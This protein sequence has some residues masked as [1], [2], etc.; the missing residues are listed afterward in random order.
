M[1][2][3]I[4]EIKKTH[5]CNQLVSDNAGEEVVL[6]GWVHTRRDL[7]KLIFID[8]RDREGITQVVFNPEI[9]KT[10]HEVAKT[11]R[12]EDVI[13]IKGKVMKR[14]DPNKDMVTGEIEILVDY[15][16]IL[17][18]AK[19]TP[20]VIEDDVDASEELRLKYRYLDLRRP[21]LQKILKTRHHAA[22]I[23]RSYLSENGFIEVE[24]PVLTK[25]TPEGARDY[26]LPSRVSKG[27]FYAL[28]QS[29]QLFKQLLMISGLERYFQ[30]AKCYRDEDLRA[31]RQPEFTQIDCEM[32]F[33]NEEDIY[34][35]MEG[36]ITKIWKD[37]KGV[38]LKRPFDR[39]THA[40]AM[41]DYGTDRPDR[42]IPWK[43]KDLTILFKESDFKVFKS[44]EESG[45]KIKGMNVQ[46]RADLSR[47]VL[48]GL[49]EFVK[50]YG[51]KGLAWLKF[52]DNEWQGSV[53][54]FLSDKEKDGLKNM[55]NVSENDLILIVA[56]GAKT[57]DDAM[58]NLRLH[59]GK[60]LGVIDDKH[61]D[62]LWV[63]DFPLFE[64]NAGEKRFVSVHHPFTSPKIEDLPLLKSDS[65][66][67]R[68]NAY[69]MVLNGNEIGG[70]SIRI[71]NAE[72][73]SQ[74]FD[75][76]KISKK[77][78][79]EKFGFLLEALSFGAPPHGGVAF[80]FD[81]I[82]MLLAGT[83]NIRDVIAFPKT[84]SASCLMTD[85][86]SDVSD[87]QLKELGIKLC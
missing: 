39:I 9:G 81:R 2:K 56:D 16:E 83:E 63:V 79:Q 14:P 28:P 58:G 36:M 8:L 20:F 17:S 85:A 62:V 40:E 71:H 7:G 74:V 69:D 60:E 78:A 76:L 3:F 75:V 64:Y 21:V 6:M 70:G 5:H 11:L 49:T 57:A 42:R 4:N 67:V 26:I 66:K 25:S 77:E 38:E 43:L 80:G 24:T 50:I 1:Q 30:L 33:V 87:A 29:P 68:S 54:K 34:N 48:D 35:I 46:G 41:H 86:P 53:A 18:K 84:T 22:Q 19:T 15:F 10:L 23:A 44:V 51:A 52:K 27:K 73:Q 45:G 55:L 72:I 12:M 31:D 65:G 37:I 59:L 47:K 82:V 61:I 13:G 32:S